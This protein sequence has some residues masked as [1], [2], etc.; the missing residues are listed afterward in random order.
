VAAWAVA[1]GLMVL[2]GTRPAR[3]A[4]SVSTSSGVNFGSYDVFSASPVGSTGQFTW[5]CAP[6]TF[7]DVRN[8]LTKGASPTYAARTMVNG[9]NTLLYNLYLDSA[10]TIVWGDESDGTEAYCPQYSGLGQINVCIDGRV[11]ASQD[12]AAGSY[13]DTVTLVINF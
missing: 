8:T 2:A 7:P 11:P 13:L 5:W 12:A 6:L 10:R 3:A 1:A 9:S 4:W